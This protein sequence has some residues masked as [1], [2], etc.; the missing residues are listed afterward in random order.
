M[1]GLAFAPLQ[2][3]GVLPSSC[4]RKGSSSHELPEFRWINTWLSNLKNQL[5]GSFH[6]FVSKKVVIAYPFWGGG[7]GASATASIGAVQ[8]L[9]A[10]TSVWFMPSLH[11]QA[12]PR[13]GELLRCAE[14][15]T[16]NRVWQC[17]AFATGRR[18]SLANLEAAL[19]D[20][21]PGF[22]SSVSSL[23]E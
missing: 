11:C 19:E 5:R 6:A 21:E 20:F 17:C 8:F 2:E 15:A 18:R 13:N 10:M 12:R 1:G 23:R 7:G 3:V 9:A 4:G 14:F 22:E 16:L